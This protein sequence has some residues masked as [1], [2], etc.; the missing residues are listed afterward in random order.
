MLKKSS[1]LVLL[2]ALLLP[3][4]G[5]LFA[6]NG[7]PSFGDVIDVR[8][9]NLEV[10][11]TAKGQRV[12]ALS[13]EDF[14][15]YIDGQEM[16]IEY[17]SEIADGRAIDVDHGAGTLPSV[18]PGE[19][20]GTNYLVFVDDFF[21]IPAYRNRVLRRLE[22]QLPFLGAEDRM[23]IVAFDGQKVEMLSSWTRSL[24]QLRAA[25]ED[26]S[27]RKAYGLQRLSE[28]QRFNTLDD[29]GLGYGGRFSRG[30]SPYAD[31]QNARYEEIGWKISRVVRGAN[32][33]LRA[34]ARPEGRKVMMLLSGGWPSGSFWGGQIGRSPYAQQAWFSNRLFEPL[35]ST[36]NRLSYTLYPVDLNNDLRNSGVS[37][38]FSTLRDANFRT[39]INRQQDWL[40]EDALIYLADATGGRAFLDGGALTALE[41]TVEDTRSYYWL[42][43]TPTWREDDGQHRIEVKVRQRGLKVRTRASYADLSRESENTMLVES[44][45]LFDLP[46][47]GPEMTVLFGEPSKSGFRKVHVPVRLELPL[48]QISLLRGS[49][50][51]SADLELRVAATDDDGD[52]APVALSTVRI[53]GNE[54]PTP[55]GTAAIETTLELRRKPHRLLISV[56][57]PV[58]GNMLSK[59]VELTL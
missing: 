53:Q 25:L 1:P 26:A 55:N 14:A 2:L 13:P 9:V 41:R 39:S 5:P 48:D 32:S 17:F 18:A 40:E 43:F 38:E 23:A 50:G 22:E 42:G 8:V 21:A 27:D 52:E 31:F 15:L 47:P 10:V 6:Q 4:A 54:A 57:D 59:R 11:V 37:A 35:V 28:L 33:A 30:F 36:A 19:E 46:L 7:G 56:F 45:H 58:S 24:P 29:F 44:A 20:V 3:L 16:P 51:Y 12:P 34:F 49:N